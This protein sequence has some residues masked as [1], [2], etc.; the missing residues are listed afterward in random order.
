MGKK[1]APFLIYDF[2][3]EFPYI[4]GKFDILFYQ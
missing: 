4:L 1:F 2:A 3:T